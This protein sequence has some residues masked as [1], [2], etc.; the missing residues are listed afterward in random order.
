MSDDAFRMPLEGLGLPPA[1]SSLPFLSGVRVLDLSSSI[2]A[3]YATM[4]LGDLGAEIIKL[5][6]RTT[7]DDSRAWGPPFLNGESLW[8]L[9]VNRGKQSVTLDFTTA[10]GLEV[11]HKLVKRCDVV[12]V[13]VGPRVQRKLGID[14]ATLKAIRP[15][16][17]FVSI[18]GFGLTGARADTA[19]YDLIAEGYSGIMDVTGEL[20]GPAQKVGAPAADLLAGMDAA[21]GVLAALIDRMNTGRG[22]QVDISMVESM[23][24]LLTPRIVTYLGSG[25]V[26]RRSGGTDSVIAI[27][28]SFDTAD[29]PMTLGLGN[30]GIWKRFWDCVG[31]PDFGS[32]PE[33]KSNS[34]RHER[35]AEI[36]AHIG[37]IL[38]KEPRD[39]WL[40]L[41]SQSRVPAGPINGIDELVE[42]EELKKRGFLYCMERDG[43]TIPQV[44]LGIRFDDEPAAPSVAPPLLGADTDDV[45]SGVLGLTARDIRQLRERSVI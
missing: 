12:V 19:A 27:Y 7:G 43:A 5:E 40:E 37:L 2:A 16:L 26:P 11:L 39:Y 17:V 38:T 45:L 21:M 29:L 3:P 33:Y 24:R 36:V 1:R 23:A 15:D 30:D 41:L 22:H 31:D 4:L 18:T 10:E 34:L 42:D 6:R 8:F 14:Y 13:N 20:D 28:Q 25:E 35:R 44:G 9:S 32:R